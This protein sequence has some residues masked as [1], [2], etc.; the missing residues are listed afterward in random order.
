MYGE[1]IIQ[2]RNPSRKEHHTQAAILPGRNII[3]KQQSFQEGISYISSIPSRK[4]YHTQAAILPGRN[5][6]HKQQSFQEGTSHTSSIPSRKGTSYTSSILPG[7]NIIHKQHS[8]HEG[9]SH[10]PEFFR[11]EQQKHL[12]IIPANNMY[13]TRLM[14][15]NN[16]MQ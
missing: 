12:I 3:H 10:R 13:L 15:R 11:N 2:S 16:E 1:N 5:I 4:E 7:R 6:I 8:F 14:N 9:T